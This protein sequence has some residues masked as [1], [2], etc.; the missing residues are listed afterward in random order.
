MPY[1][2]HEDRLRLQSRAVERPQTAGELNF[3]I[4]ELCLTFLHDKQTT[5]YAAINEIV[6]AL[7]CCKLELYRRLAAPYEDI[8][9]KE[10]GDVYL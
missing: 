8:K 10:N 5:N 4:T 7:E 2:K 9:I 6:G 1:I 3:K